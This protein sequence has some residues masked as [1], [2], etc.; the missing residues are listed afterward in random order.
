[1]PVS[2]DLYY[3][4]YHHGGEDA[5]PLVLIHGAGGTHL[6][7]PPEIRRL[8]GYRVYALDMPGHGKSEA[9]GGLQTI[10]DYAKHV[11][12]W[13]DSVHLPRAVLVG[14]SMG[15]AVALALAIHHPEHVLGLGLIGAG[16]RLRVHPALLE[17]AA[18]PTTFY[19]VVETL[20]SWSFSPNAQP[21]LVELAYKR[22]TETRQSVLY[23]DLLAC[24]SFDVM[25]HLGL[26]HQ[27]T[28]VI[29]GADDQMTPLR[30]AQYLSNSI[31][32]A[33]LAE[34]PNA[35]HMVMLE[36]PRAVADALLSFLKDVP[37]HPGEV[38]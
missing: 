31:P 18:N 11:L 7:W 12:F 2:S 1:M 35:G 14:H 37:F 8:Q 25:D 10:G 13:L 38:P 32:A 5:P 19:K 24:N 29:C 27:P 36:Q 17:S 30:Y 20:V 28:L 34:I 3:S 33:H 9:C 16:A 4:L 23:G 15:S 22:M 6:H 21:R 26:I